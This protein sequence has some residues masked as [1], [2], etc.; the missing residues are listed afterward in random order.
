M[1]TGLA[2][3]DME[4]LEVELHRDLAGSL[5]RIAEAIE[6]G[7][8]DGRVLQCRANGFLGGRGDQRAHVLVKLDLAAEIRRPVEVVE[9]LAAGAEVR[10]G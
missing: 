5:R 3:F 1:V 4:R 2:V 6:A 9:A 7:E 10:R 8:L